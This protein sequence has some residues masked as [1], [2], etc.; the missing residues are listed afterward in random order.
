MF[1]Q[2][3]KT[4]VFLMDLMVILYT[5]TDKNNELMPTHLYKVYF[6]CTIIVE[7]FSTICRDSGAV[8]T[9]KTKTDDS[10]DEKVKESNDKKSN[11]SSEVTKKKKS[12]SNGFHSFMLIYK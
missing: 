12:S 1:C 3:G 10:K 6:R 9:K 5:Y 11:T 7:F 2:S 4:R 8:S